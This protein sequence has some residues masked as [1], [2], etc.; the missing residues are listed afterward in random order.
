MQ[1]CVAYGNGI[2][3]ENN[4]GNLQLPNC[5]GDT[6]SLHNR[7]GVNKAVWFVHTAGWCSACGDWMAQVDQLDQQEQANDIE[8]YYILGQ[9]SLYEI[10]KSTSFRYIIW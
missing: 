6:V 1:G 9:T 8:V 7:C 4:I 3:I 2:G 5:N 10:H